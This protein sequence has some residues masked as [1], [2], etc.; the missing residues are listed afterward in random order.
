VSSAFGPRTARSKGRNIGVRIEQEILREARRLIVRHE[1]KGRLLAEEHDRRTKRSTAAQPPLKLR[2]PSHWS[3]DPGFDPYLTRSRSERISH[4]VRA[5]LAARAYRPRHPYSFEVAKPDGGT[6]TVCIYQVADSAVSKMIFEGVLKKN[7]PIL[8]A[9]AYA[10]RKDLSAQNAIQYLK[11]EFT[12]RSRLYVAEYDFRKYFDT[13]SHDHIRRVLEAYFLLTAVERHAIEGFLRVGPS[14]AASYEPIDGP[15]R[16]E[17]I[18]QGTSI[19]LFLANVAAWELDRALEGHG[20]G[21]VRYADDTL[22]WSS[23]YSRICS[24]VDLLH[25]HAEAIGVT[26]NSAKSPGIRLLVP[27]GAVGEIAVTYYVDYL[28]HR[29]GTDGVRMKPATEDRLRRRVDQMIFNSLLREPIAGTQAMSRL[30]VN[31]DRDYVS[32]IARLRRYLY[33]DLSEK[34]L[35]Q[36]QTRGAPLRRFRG[37]MSAY[38]LLDDTDALADLDEWILDRLW[39]AIRKRGALLSSAGATLL[40]PPHG[41]SRSDLR[42]LAVKSARTG[43]RIDLASPSVRRI[44]NVLADAAARYGPAAIGRATVYDY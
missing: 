27:D 31:V 32:V 3:V 15:E 11:S 29:I 16:T 18:P 13:I 21:F 8:S 44:A 23:D 1:T 40:P 2:R 35:R 25:R 9:R 22:I 5:S 24:A 42:N 41:L 17:G 12:G 14:S 37:V 34:A 20:V 39:L 6:R 38:P 7:L 28:G 19:S 26:V 43:Q 30:A 36:Y 33:G 4:S 10:Y